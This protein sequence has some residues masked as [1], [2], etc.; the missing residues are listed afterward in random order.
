M[1]KV[2]INE[3]GLRDGLQIQPKIVP[4]EGKIELAQALVDSGI[5]SFEA[6]SFVSPKAVPQMADAVEVFKNLP[7]KDKTYYSALLFNEKG[8]ERAINAGAKSIAVALASTDKMN[9]ANIRMSLEE[10][11]RYLY[12]DITS[13]QQ[14]YM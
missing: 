7:A 11:T 6:A 1:T 8:Y 2:T 3:V 12:L 10:A 14:A 13:F 9:Q 5:S 4:L